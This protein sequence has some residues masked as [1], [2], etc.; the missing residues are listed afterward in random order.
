M[1]SK[2]IGIEHDEGNNFV[3]VRIIQ[4]QNIIPYLNKLSVVN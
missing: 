2:L 3:D 4:S 1:I